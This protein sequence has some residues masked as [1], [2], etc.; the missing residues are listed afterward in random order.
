MSGRLDD[1]A[2]QLFLQSN[3]HPTAWQLT[4]R[5]Y[6]QAW[7]AGQSP[8]AWEKNKSLFAKAFA[9][10]LD[11][12]RSDA[13]KNTDPNDLWSL[14][15]VYLRCLDPALNRPE[16]AQQNRYLSRKILVAGLHQKGDGCH[17]AIS[18]AFREPALAKLRK[19]FPQQSDDYDD[20]YQNAL[21]N[22]LERPPPQDEQ[23][24]AQ[25][26]TWF[27]R[28]LLRRMIDL[29]RGKDKQ[30]SNLEITEVNLLEASQEEEQTQLAYLDHLH[31]KYRIG[32]RFA[33][34]DV[35]LIVRK[36]IAQLG[37][38]CEQII[39]QR[40]LRRRSYR[41][42][43]VWLDCSVNDI[44]QRIKRCLKKLREQLEPP[45]ASK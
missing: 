9:T 41:E 5:E 44:G 29:Q 35:G 37:D 22:L 4:Y 8:E 6:R 30:I 26:Y 21:L 28:V 2:L 36:A 43:A 1:A 17:D 10:W 7:L 13:M 3:L 16:L 42:L 38:N 31:E 12:I 24:K 32:E 40:Y 39:T 25:L 15:L 34:D 14:F 11:D 18:R 45:K 20:A 27:I 23:P 33:S 19:Q